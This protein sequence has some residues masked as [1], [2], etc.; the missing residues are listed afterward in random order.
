VALTLQGLTSRGTKLWPVETD[1][2]KCPLRYVK[3]HLQKKESMGGRAGWGGG[4]GEVLRVR[5]SRT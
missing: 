4:G 5:L 3:Y 1:Q 2:R